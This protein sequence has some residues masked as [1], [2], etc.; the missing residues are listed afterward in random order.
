MW[1]IHLTRAISSQLYPVAIQKLFRSYQIL[2]FNEI[3]VLIAV[4]HIMLV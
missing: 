4:P 1:I 2:T 3:D